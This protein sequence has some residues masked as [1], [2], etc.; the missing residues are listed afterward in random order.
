MNS[1]IKTT[2]GTG[3]SGNSGDGDLAIYG[4]INWPW[5]I[6]AAPDGSIYFTDRLNENI[7]KVDP[8][9]IITKVNAPFYGVYG[10]NVS[11]DG[12]LYYVSRNIGRIY[13]VSPDGSV[14]IFR[15]NVVAMDVAVGQD[16][17]VFYTDSNS[18]QVKRIGTDGVNTGFLPE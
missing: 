7:R 4:K 1:I 9:G 6:A 3:V 14:S 11:S 18:H 5:D 17:S 13:R 2:T 12:S 15:E 8:D 10:L 16:G